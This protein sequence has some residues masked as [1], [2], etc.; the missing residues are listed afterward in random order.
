MSQSKL[1]PEYLRQKALQDAYLARKNKKTD[2]MRTYTVAS[3]FAFFPA[4]IS[5]NEDM[6]INDFLESRASITCSI[7]RF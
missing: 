4:C 5:L 2:L 1:H 7:N 6:S 3:T